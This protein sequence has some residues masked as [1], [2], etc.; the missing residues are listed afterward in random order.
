MTLAKGFI[1]GLC[2][3]V[4]SVLTKLVFEFGESSFFASS[5]FLYFSFILFGFLSVIFFNGLMFRYFAL[6][7]SE[8]NTLGITVVISGFIKELS[9]FNF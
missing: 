6:G 3:S 4:A 9:R 5:K 1:G 7:A 2:A 8:S